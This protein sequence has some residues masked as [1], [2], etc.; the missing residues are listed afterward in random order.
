MPSST[1]GT[2]GELTVNA[3]TSPSESS[4]TKGGL[5]PRHVPQRTCVACRQKDAKRHY[6]RLVRTPTGDVHVDPTGKA[7]GRGAYLCAR[8]SCWD[9]ALETNAVDRALTVT[10]SAEQKHELAEWARAHIPP[11]TEIS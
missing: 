3:K 10:L 1:K 9:R 7:N 11:D 5:R 4:R 2:I 6:V 8:R